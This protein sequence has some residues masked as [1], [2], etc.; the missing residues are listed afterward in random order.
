MRRKYVVFIGGVPV[1]FLP[2]EAE[3]VL[4]KEFRIVHA[5]D[6]GALERVVHTWQQQSLLQ[7]VALVVPSV[8]DAWKH[9]MA[10]HELVQA[11][12]GAVADEQGRLLAIHRLGLWDLPKG[13]A[14]PGETAEGTA[15]REV[16]EECGIQ[17]LTLGQALPDTW[18][19]YTRNGVHCLKCTKWFSM[20]A[21]SEQPLVA[22]E[23]EDIR[24]VAWLDAEARDRMAQETYPSLLPV[25]SAWEERHHP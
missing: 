3:A 17:G 13:K 18:H 23:S 24:E 1:H 8:Q 10:M 14:E 6:K 21:N 25:I 16:K 11:A 20:Y 15:M 2:H 19:T 4:G 7:P 22:Q 9:F 5:R 12:G